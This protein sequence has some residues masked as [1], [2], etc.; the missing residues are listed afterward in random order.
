LVG[1]VSFNIYYI[2]EPGTLALLGLGALG[3]MVFRRK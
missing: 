3:L 2:P 1:L